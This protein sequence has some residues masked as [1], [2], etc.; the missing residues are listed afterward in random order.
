MLKKIVYED[1]RADKAV[2]GNIVSEEDGFYKIETTRGNTMYIRKDRVF[3]I[4][5]VDEE[6]LY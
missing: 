5:D 1:D 2:V 6:G 3:L 4:K